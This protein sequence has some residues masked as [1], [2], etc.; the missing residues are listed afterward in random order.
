MPDPVI[1]SAPPQK[2]DLPECELHIWRA[3]LD[4]EPEV[5][6]RISSTL[7]NDEKARAA[8]FHFARDRDHFTACRG[9]LRE[10]LGEYLGSSPAS[11]EFSYGEFGKPA[12]RPRDSRPCIGFNVSHS[13]GLAV[14]AFARNCEIGIDLEPISPEFA[15]VEIAKRYFSA[16]ELAE[17]IALPAE[18]RPEGFSLC[19]TRKEA[20][21]KARG[22]G[23]QI[24]LDSFSVSLTPNRPV[25]LQSVDSQRWS[26][27]SF[28]PAPDFV[29][30]L[31]HEGVHERLHKGLQEGQ[32]LHPRYWDWSAQR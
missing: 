20:Y 27:R 22:L 17:M 11:I 21:V 15:G 7:D 9:I 3:N 25:L 8:R 6:D 30:A 10:L 31:V 24:P 12:H 5:L 2:L 16:R 32:E 28:K 23:L 29:A 13:S 19:W 4:L 26:L 14:L 1:W 18:L